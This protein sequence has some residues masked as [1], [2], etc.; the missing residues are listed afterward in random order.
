MVFIAAAFL[1]S[2]FPLLA[3]AA[4]GHGSG[5]GKSISYLYLSNIIGSTL[6]SFVVGFIIL[7]RFSTRATSTFLLVLGLAVYLVLIF[8]SRPAGKPATVI[9]GCVACLFL[10]IGSGPLYSNI[11]ERLLAKSAYQPGRSLADLVENRSGT[12]AVTKDGTVYGGGIYDGRFNVDPMNDTNGIFRAY[13][14]AGMHPKPTNVL[15]IGLSSGSWTQVL[16]NNPAVKD[17][18]A[19][20][21]NP[22]YLSLIAKHP[23]VQSL[24]SNPNV[25]MVADDG[26]RW[27]V[28][29]PDRKFD[30]ILINMTFNWRANASNLLSREFLILLRSHLNPS[31]IAFYNTTWSDEAIAT[32]LS[33]FPYALRVTDF[34]AV[35]DAPFTL[36]PELWRQKLTDY[37]IN[38]RSVFDLSNPLHRRRFEEVLSGPRQLDDPTGFYESRSSMLKHIPKSPIITDDNMGTEWKR[39]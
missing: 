24:L 16:A 28:S 25:H 36:D 18:T 2:A 35:S 21:I 10:A 20:E 17:I 26:R 32:G 38:G 33:V 5:A 3:H 6:G 31:G 30:F 27:L 12:I 14:I 11:H 29:H 37:Q 22:G 8:L 19:V 34:L 4:I 9:A 1:G 15:V 13:A 39:E 23:E 7:D